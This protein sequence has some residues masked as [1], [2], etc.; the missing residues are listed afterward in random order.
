[1]IQV[2]EQVS[3]SR[4]MWELGVGSAIAVPL[5][6]ED[7]TLGVIYADV[8]ATTPRT[9]EARSVGLLSVVAN[10]A[11]MAIEQNR[12]LARVREEEQ[13]RSASSGTSPDRWW[14]GSWPTRRA[15]RLRP[16]PGVRGHRPVLRHGRLH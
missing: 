6:S 11:A 7:R 16:R 13:R 4:S 15:R 9:F 10:Y 3:T 12:L 1:V 8:L 2:E 5:W 14:I